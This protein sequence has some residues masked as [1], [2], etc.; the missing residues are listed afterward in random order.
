MKSSNDGPS[1]RVE[2]NEGLV[3]VEAE[4]AVANERTAILEDR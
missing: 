3:E 4:D 2:L 1:S